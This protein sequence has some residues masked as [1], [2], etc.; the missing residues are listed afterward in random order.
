LPR[1]WISFAGPLILSYGKTGFQKDLDYFF[2]FLK[3]FLSCFAPHYD[4][5]M[6]CRCSG[7][8]HQFQ[9]SLY[10][11]MVNGRTV[12]PAL[13]QP[14]PGENLLRVRAGCGLYSAAKEIKKTKNILTI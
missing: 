7:A 13:R 9:D 8:S 5:I 4:V 11:P 3:N 6:Y 14:V 12:I 10:H 2:P 1:N